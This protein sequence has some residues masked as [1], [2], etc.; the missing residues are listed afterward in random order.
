MIFS[1]VTDSSSCQSRLHCSLL[2]C[3]KLLQNDQFIETKYE[4]Q[5]NAQRDPVAMMVCHQYN[6]KHVLT[7]QIH[8]CI[9]NNSAMPHESE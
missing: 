8:A 3:R 5:I 1:K 2:V 4:V 7:I 9:P 6:M